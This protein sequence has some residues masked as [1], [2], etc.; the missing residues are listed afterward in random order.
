MLNFARFTLAALLVLTVSP[1]L[2][3]QQWG[4]LKMK[5]VYDGPP[6][7]PQTIDPT[8]DVE[9]CGKH[10][11]VNEE[12]LVDPS[13]GIANVV[14]WVRT[15]G[16]KVAPQ[17][18]AAEKKVMIYDNKGCRFEPHVLA[19]TTSEELELHNSDPISHNSN[20]APLGGNAIN[21][22]LPPNGEALYTFGRPTLV[23]VPV[24]CNIHPWMKGYIVARDNPYVAVSKPDGSLEI[25]DLPA[26]ELEFQAW[27]EKSGYV[28][29]PDWAKGR[30]TLTIKPGDNDLGTIKLPPQLFNK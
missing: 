28:A 8:K 19:M 26:E 25:N 18:V 6:P 22:L 9:V 3:A 29:T 4:N 2:F 10:K 21:P 12:L 23:P 30:F 27:Q 1:A 7:T 14:V 13:G 11:L 24:T 17:A 15:K 20:M 5:F 16:V